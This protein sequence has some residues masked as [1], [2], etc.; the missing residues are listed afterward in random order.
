M[1]KILV[2]CAPDPNTNPRPNRMI[3]W[4]KS[5]CDLTV[6]GGAKLQLNGI[7][8][9]SLYGNVKKSTQNS[10]INI[11]LINLRKHTY[12]TF[13][14]LLFL[15]TKR[16]EDILWAKYYQAKEIGVE[17]AEENFDLIISHDL[18]LLPLV[19]A[20]KGNKS[21]KIMLDA[22]EYYP[23]NFNDSMRWR[24]LTKPINKYLCEKYLH[25]CDKIITVSDGLAKKYA[26]EYD[27]QEPNII[28]SLPATSSLQ[29][30]R[31]NKELIK[32]IHHGNANS[33]RKT[34]L[35]VEMMDFVDK[36]FSL[37]LMLINSKTDKYWNKLNDMAKTRDNVRVI[38]PVAMQKIVPFINQYDIGLYLTFPTNFNVRYMLPNKLFEFIQACL[39]VAIGPSVEMQKIVNQYDCGIISK[40]FEPRSLA[41]ELNKLTP[42]KL[43]YYKEQS[44]KAAQEL[45][46]DV[47]KERILRLIDELFNE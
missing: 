45:N 6:V 10:F 25:R 30:S 40:D 2:V 46:A 42:E 12:Y 1:K 17:L 32:I 44:H 21:T 36:H 41:K 47:N 4:L 18:V 7:R 26:K 13:R 28:M 5:S 8:S 35:M 19:F 3:H 15:F 31:T 22:R 33:S 34:E 14:Y 20:I 11:F 43:A 27:V 37:D 38:P 9:F 23:L 24:L 29:P 39:V 16:Y